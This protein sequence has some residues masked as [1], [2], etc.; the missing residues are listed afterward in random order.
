MQ[1]NQ[2]LEAISVVEK[3]EML[4]L[5][6]E[7]IAVLEMQ[8]IRGSVLKTREFIEELSNVFY[9]VKNSYKKQILALVKKKRKGHVVNQNTIS[10]STLAKNGKEIIVL[11]SANTKLYGDIVSKT[12]NAFLETIKNNPKVDIAIVG[13]LGK[14]LF[15]REKLS[16]PYAYFGLPDVQVTLEHVKPI[17]SHIVQFEKVAVYYGKFINVIE[18]APASAI[19][20]GEQPLAGEKQ[21]S[22]ENFRFI[23]EP[24]LEKILNFFETQIFSALF[25]QTVHEYQLARH[26]SRITA[27]EYALGN[28][29]ITSKD[30]QTQKRRMKH[31]VAN[32]KLLS[33]L[34]GMTLWNT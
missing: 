19:I 32:K 18:Q 25:K 4:A 21:P 26:A 8:K 22:R 27:M 12:F 5:A 1:K 31:S 7:E 30:L 20:S 3:F 15:D 6:Y 29:A 34:S 14:E 23:F 9:D 24:E 28:I 13:K 11:L 33:S 17:I 10:F 2:L 16:R